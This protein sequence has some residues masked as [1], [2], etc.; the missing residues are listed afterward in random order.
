M[1]PGTISSDYGCTL[2]G[3]KNNGVVN[4]SQ[5]LFQPKYETYS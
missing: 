4:L 2:K 3:I 1:T 5:A